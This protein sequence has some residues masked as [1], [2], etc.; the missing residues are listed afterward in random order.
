MP[1]F[2]VLGHKFV[3]YLCSS[4]ACSWWGNQ[5]S[6]IWLLVG[7]HYVTL[8]CSQT[9]VTSMYELQT[10]CFCFTLKQTLKVVCIFSGPLCWVLWNQFIFNHQKTRD[11]VLV[12]LTYNCLVYTNFFSWNFNGTVIINLSYEAS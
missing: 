8:D 1:E 11:P 7:N 3:S 4:T 12:P 10:C 6:C 2:F 5:L 9:Q